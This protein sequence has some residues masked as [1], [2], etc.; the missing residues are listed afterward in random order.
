MEEVHTAPPLNRMEEV[1]SAPPLNR[2][3]IAL[4][5]L[6][7]VLLSAYLTLY[8]LGLIGT[9][10]CGTGSCETVQASKWAVFFG[11]PVPVVG[12]LGYAALLAIALVALQPNWL[13]DRKLM[14]ALV[15]LAS[16][17]LLFSVYL[18]YLE[19]FVIHAWCRWCIVSAVIATLIWLFSLPELPRLRRAP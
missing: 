16:G 19:M 6:L 10:A 1:R 2:M 4:L 15:L 13:G 12:L 7:G 17:G 9:L 18:S 5:A 14:L 8:K 3:A 11:V